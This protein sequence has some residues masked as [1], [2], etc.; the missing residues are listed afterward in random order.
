MRRGVVAFAG[1]VCLAGPLAAQQLTQK[2]D[3]KPVRQI[4][5][6]RFEL[7]KI[8]IN[9]I[10]FRSSAPPGGLPRHSTSEAVVRFDNKGETAAAV[11]VALVLFDGEGNIVAA[12]SGGTRVSWLMPG[13]GDT[14]TIR[15]PFVY[16]N[17][18]KAKTFLLTMEIQRKPPKPEARP[19]PPPP[20]VS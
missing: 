9:Q 8:Q 14:S 5:E 1:A 3:Y 4:Q 15:F 2:F 17:L 20:P 16:R 7:E 6:I 10:V 11:G 18:E 12:G 19:T 13:E